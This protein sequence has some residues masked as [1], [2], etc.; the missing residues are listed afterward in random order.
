MTAPLAKAIAGL[1]IE[2]EAILRQYGWEGPGGIVDPPPPPKK[3][4]P[5]PLICAVAAALILAVAVALWGHAGAG[6]TGKG[7]TLRADRLENVKSYEDA[8]SRCAFGTRYSRDEVSSIAFSSSMPEGAEEGWDVYEAGD[9][10]VLAWFNK[11]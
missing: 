5:I 7:G 2:T 10:S 3:K 1:R 8:G 9:G 4:P 11:N 6:P